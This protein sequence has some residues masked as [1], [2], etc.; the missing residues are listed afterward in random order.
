MS[1]YSNFNVDL[2]N[3]NSSWT[4]LYHKIDEGATVLDIGCSSGYFDEVLVRQKKCAV[5]GVEM[6]P[7]DAKR[8]KKICRKVV[9]GNIES[10]DF[11]WDLID[12]KYDHI[13][14][15]DVLEHLID[16]ARTLQNVSKLLKE[17]GSILFSIPNMANGSVRLQLLQGNFDY[18]KEGLLDET[19]LHYYTD[20]TITKM[21]QVSKLKLTDIDFT[22]FDTPSST[23]RTVMKSVGLASTPDFEKYLRSGTALIYQYIGTVQVHG[24]SIALPGRMQAIKPKIDY[25]KQIAEV[26]DDT[27]KVFKNLINANGIINKQHAEIVSLKEELDILRNEPPFKKIKRTIKG[28]INR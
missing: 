27:R 8:A 22:T 16:P 15:I 13:L 2:T 10:N 17:N 6:D 25:E 7:A 11:P 26:Q 18:E 9:E 20:Y 23:I 28:I 14:F 19:H 3:T 12:Q 5:D 21:I 4:I 1:S 24:T